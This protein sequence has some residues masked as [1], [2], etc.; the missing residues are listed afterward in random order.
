[1]KL[2]KLNNYINSIDK[3]KAADKDDMKQMTINDVAAKLL[4]IK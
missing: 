4:L 2:E 3:I 1:M